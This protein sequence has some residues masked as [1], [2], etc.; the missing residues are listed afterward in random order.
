VVDRGKSWLGK[1]DYSQKKWHCNQYGSYRQD[2]SGYVSMM[3]GLS[4]SRTTADIRGVTYDIG[5]GN[6]QPGDALWHRRNGFN[7]VALF[8]GWAN[9]NGEAWVYE[10]YDYGHKAEQRKWSASKVN[11]FTPIRYRNIH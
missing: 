6:L 4:Y 7:H 10:E 11:M 9:G 3:W 5:R 8:V 2:C 1:V